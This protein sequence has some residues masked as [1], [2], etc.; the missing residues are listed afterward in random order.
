MSGNTWEVS[1]NSDGFAVLSIGTTFEND[2]LGPEFRDLN[3][4]GEA[5][6]TTVT[7]SFWT[8]VE[9]WAE[10]ALPGSSV[11]NSGPQTTNYKFSTNFDFSELGVSYVNIRIASTNNTFT[12]YSNPV[13]L[14]I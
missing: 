8:V 5:G 7:W 13:Q 4:S 10:W 6:S 3:I 14:N 12:G 11:W 9:S 2:P 1:M